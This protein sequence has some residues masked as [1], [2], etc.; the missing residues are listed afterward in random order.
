MAIETRLLKVG[1]TLGFLACDVRCGDTDALLL[2][3]HHTKYLSIDKRWDLFLHTPVRHLTLPTL[4]AYLRFWP[5]PTH[6]HVADATEADVFDLRERDGAVELDVARGPRGEAP[7]RFA[8]AGT[9]PRGRSTEPRRRRGT[10][11]ARAHA[12]GQTPAQAKTHCNGLGSLHGGAACVAAELAASRLRGNPAPATSMHVS[13]MSS[14][15]AGRTASMKLDWASPASA[16]VGV[17]DKRSGAL[18]YDAR[19][20]YS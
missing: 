6:S 7:G 17:Y 10:A 16:H 8:V 12:D 2:R 4:A 20:G 14:I 3:G 15:V 18:C 5:H 19:L 9:T 1:K 13:L 11:E